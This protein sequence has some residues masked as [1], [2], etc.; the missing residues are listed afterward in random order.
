VRHPA[1]ATLA[2]VF[3][4]AAIDAAPARA[5]NAC[6][7]DKVAATYDWQVVSAAAR[8]GHTVVFA[9]LDGPVTPGDAGLEMSLRRRH[10]AVQG[11]DAGSV[12]TSLA[13]PAVSFAADLRR[14][15]VDD[16]LAAMNRALRPSGHG[17]TLVRVGAPGDRTQ[18]P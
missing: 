5:C 13:P 2:A 17:L 14:R 12:R 18:M 7:E 9:R 10:D 3:L 15:R 16:L 11:V 6:V 8:S 1:R 4:A